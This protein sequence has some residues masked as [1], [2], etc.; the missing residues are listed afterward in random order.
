MSETFV[1]RDPIE[2]M[3]REGFEEW[4]SSHE[5]NTQMGDTKR[6]YKARMESERTRY[7][8]GTWFDWQT[9]TRW[10]MWQD[11]FL[12]GASWAQNSN[13]LE[14]SNPGDRRRES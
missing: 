3:M 14:N 8:Y 13:A 1:V 11:A 4:E 12:K 6:A 9:N 5:L 10:K 2:L 7:G